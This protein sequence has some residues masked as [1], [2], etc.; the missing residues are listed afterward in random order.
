MTY[1]KIVAPTGQTLV[2][3][4]LKLEKSRKECKVC[5]LSC[6]SRKA[7]RDRIGARIENKNLWSGHGHW[8]VSFGRGKNM[9]SRKRDKYWRHLRQFFFRLVKRIFLVSAISDTKCRISFWNRQYITLYVKLTAGRIIN[10]W[11]MLSS[12]GPSILKEKFQKV[13]DK[14][15][16]WTWPIHL[17]SATNF[18]FNT[19]N[20]IWRYPLE[21]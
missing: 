2:E 12:K 5:H 13:W 1:Y 11:T 4:N 7:E 3:W 10:L 8:T 20:V 14:T 21:I 9:H 15:L 6:S 19:L 18:L 16:I 17:F